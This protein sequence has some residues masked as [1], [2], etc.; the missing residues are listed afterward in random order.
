MNPAAGTDA[1]P[2][3][4][5][6]ITEG[7]RDAVE[8]LDTAMTRGPGDATNLARQ[9]A[10]DGYDQLFVA[11]GDGTLNEVLNGVAQ[12]PG[13]WDAVT[14]GVIPLGTGNDFA[15]AVGIPEDI[16]RAIQAL[17]GGTPAAVDMGCLNDAVYFVNVSAGGFMAE[18]SDAVTPRLKTFAGKLA[19][20]IGGAQ[21]LFDYE[22]FRARV[23]SHGDDATDVE[24]SLHTYAVCNSPL[25]G[26]G[27][28]IAPAARLDDGLVDVCLIEA[29]STMDFLGL[30]TRV[31]SGEHVNDERVRYFR[32]T[33]V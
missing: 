32:A 8:S 6:T 24:M 11:G 27:R 15:T 29:M 30:L 5:R 17:V 18:V 1:G 16:E 25:V 13:G 9:A 23:V 12:V 19:Y 26:G 20:L 10:E 4:L 7:L 14:F 22:P 3:Y 2:D 21:V 33:D 31:S 28:L